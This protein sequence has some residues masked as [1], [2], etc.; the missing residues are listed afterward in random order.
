[1]EKSR[2]GGKDREIGRDGGMRRGMKGGMG[3]RER[4]KG[5]GGEGQKE[6]RFAGGGVSGLAKVCSNNGCPKKVFL[7]VQKG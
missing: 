7:F 4:K 3:G 6:R 2:R 5:G 1:M